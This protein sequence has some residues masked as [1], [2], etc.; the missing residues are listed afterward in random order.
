[1]P[2]KSQAPG[3]QLKTDPALCSQSSQSNGER[4]H[5]CNWGRQ[6]VGAHEDKSPSIT[7][8]PDDAHLHMFRGEV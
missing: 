6:P 2:V 4:P 3:L 8:D 7:P 5:L 1:M